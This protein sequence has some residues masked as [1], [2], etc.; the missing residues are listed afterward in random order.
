VFIIGTLVS[1]GSLF[2]SAVFVKTSFFLHEVV[3]VITMGLWAWS[4]FLA[5][6][7]I[8]G[9]RTKKYL[10]LIVCIYVGIQMV[11]A[12]LTGTKDIINTVFQ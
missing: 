10:M 12:S 4:G 5:I 2:L 9:E 8:Y 6:C 3:V 7:G 11:V 1:Y